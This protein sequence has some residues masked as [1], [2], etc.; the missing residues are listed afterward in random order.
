LLHKYRT[1][2]GQQNSNLQSPTVKKNSAL[3]RITGKA[4]IVKANKRAGIEQ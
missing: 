4:G 3:G 1:A 2:T